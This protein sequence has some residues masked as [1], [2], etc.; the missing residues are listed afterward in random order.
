MAGKRVSA[1]GSL[2]GHR[3]RLASTKLCKSRNLL[4]HPHRTTV[5]QTQCTRLFLKP[6]LPPDLQQ[7]IE[8]IAQDAGAEAVAV[9]CHDYE[10]NTTFSFQGDRW[11]H[12]ASTIKI[13]I[14]LSLFDAID[15]G[16]FTLTDRLHVRNRF[17]SAAQG[18]PYRVS[19]GRDAN[20]DVYKRLGLTMRLGELAHH[21]IATSSNLATNLLVDLLGAEAVQQ[22]L[23][24][25]GLSGIDFQRGVED[26]A[27]FEARINNRVTADGLVRFYRLLY[28]QQ[29]LTE[30]AAQQM[31][32]ILFAQQFKSGI[33]AR[34][35][36]DDLKKSLYLPYASR[37]RC[38]NNA[39]SR[40]RW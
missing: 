35:R 11:F 22:R 17:L 34:N 13:V 21:M 26:G 8:R 39:P 33:P 28:E 37:R 3:T 10:T 5:E 9:A 1:L 36:G 27:A 4:H 15:E 14:L 29:D 23:K 24:A 31:L 7:D 20:S 25:R 19:A 30:D 18:E 38:L 6:D 16:R 40:S 12:A 32:D 2:T